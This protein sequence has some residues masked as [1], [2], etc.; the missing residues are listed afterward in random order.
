M[1]GSAEGDVGVVRAEP[2]GEH[3]LLVLGELDERLELLGRGALVGVDPFGVEDDER[4]VRVQRPFLGID[5]HQRHP[6]RAEL[7]ARGEHAVGIAEVVV[8]DALLLDGDGAGVGQR[9]AAGVGG[10]PVVEERHRDVAVVDDGGLDVG[11]E[12][13]GGRPGEI[14]DRQVGGLAGRRVV[15][16]DREVEPA[17]REVRVRLADAERSPLGVAR[18]LPSPRGRWRAAAGRRSRSTPRASR[19]PRPSVRASR[20]PAA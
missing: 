8:D 2:E 20:S 15:L 17:R 4:V 12:L 11:G 14:L 10:E 3:L 1:I 6:R 19:A 7:L 13:D 18:A 5:R 9:R 16:G